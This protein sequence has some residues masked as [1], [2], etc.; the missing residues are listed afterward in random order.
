MTAHIT[1]Q[2]L[3]QL[4]RYDAEAGK[5]YWLPR[6]LAMFANARSGK[7]WNSRYAGKEA[8]TADNGVGYRIGSVFNRHVLAHRAAWAIV[9]GEWPDEEIDHINGRPADNRFSNLRAVSR[10]ENMRNMARR[11]DNKSGFVGVQPHSSG[12]GWYAVISTKEGLR[13]LGY[14]DL[15]GDAIAARKSAEQSNGYHPNH[16]RRA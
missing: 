16:G 14:F 6:P 12:K 15:K 3:R 9:T 8:I 1:P 7:S 4:L 11:S 13:Y 2:V 5:L 10:A